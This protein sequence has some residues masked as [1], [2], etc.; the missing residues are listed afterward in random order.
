VQI[1]K[2]VRINKCTGL[3]LRINTTIIVYAAWSF[4]NTPKYMIAVIIPT[5]IKTYPLIIQND[6][7][8]AKLNYHIPSF[9]EMYILHKVCCRLREVEN[10][11][12]FEC[13]GA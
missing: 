10:R 11:F 6:N 1:K 8:A 4:Y 3:L 12:D 9:R 13:V 2:I 7:I 5:G